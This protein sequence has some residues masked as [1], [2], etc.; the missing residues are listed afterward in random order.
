V[1]VRVTRPLEDK[2][3][4]GVPLI[5]Q[6]SLIVAKQAGKPEFGAARLGLEVEQIE[7]PDGSILLAK[8][9]VADQYGGAGVAGKVSNHYGRI[10]FGATLSALLSVGVRLPT[11][12]TEGFV[13]TI[14]QD[15]TRSLGQDIAQTGRQIIQRE[16]DRS[17]TI[18]LPAGTPVRMHPNENIHF[19]R[20]PKIVR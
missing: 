18:T 20:G 10:L 5:P 13:P 9:Q 1:V 19:V 3:L 11:G 16:L 7:L 4:Q 8:S 2:Q 6:H 17:P 12:N 14:G 15:V